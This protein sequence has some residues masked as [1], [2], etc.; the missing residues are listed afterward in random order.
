MEWIYLS[1]CLYQI[2]LLE[3]LFAVNLRTESLIIQ[4][5]WSDTL[6]QNGSS[7]TIGGLDGASTDTLTFPE[8]QPKTAALENNCTQLEPS[9][10]TAQ[11]NTVK[12]VSKLTLV[13]NANLVDGS[14]TTQQPESKHVRFVLKRTVPNATITWG[15]ANGVQMGSL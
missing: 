15:V 12:P 14:S 9:L 4:S 6:K 3:E 1:T 10:P 11:F 2:K 5:F 7:K 8:T 13:T